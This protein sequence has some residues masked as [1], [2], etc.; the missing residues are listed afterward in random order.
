MRYKKRNYDP[1]FETSNTNNLN[2]K[3]KNLNK[4]LLSTFFAATVIATTINSN[5]SF[6]LYLCFFF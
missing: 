6:E 3:I 5:S 2:V 4:F 1:H